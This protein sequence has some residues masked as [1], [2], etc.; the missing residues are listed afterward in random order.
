MDE[1]KLSLVVL[2]RTVS[3]YCL[4]RDT[5]IARAQNGAGGRDR[6][7]GDQSWI[8]APHRAVYGATRGS[9]V[10]YLSR[11]FHGGHVRAD[12][13]ENGNEIRREQRDRHRPNSSPRST[14]GEDRSAPPASLIRRPAWLGS[15]LVPPIFA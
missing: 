3:R 8:G 6:S 5:R 9:V 15:A 13:R 1:Q 11:P 12:E 7:G 10:D 4:E 2:S 14:S